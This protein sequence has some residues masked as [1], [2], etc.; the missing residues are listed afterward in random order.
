MSEGTHTNN[1][2][3]IKKQSQELIEQAFQKGFKA[4][5][6]QGRKEGV[7]TTAETVR[8]AL[9]MDYNEMNDTINRSCCNLS[10]G[11]DTL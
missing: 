5:L 9:S 3:G 1:V 8:K 6:E 2:N 11:G 7:E 10:N 4:G